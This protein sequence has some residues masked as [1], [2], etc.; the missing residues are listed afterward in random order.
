MREALGIRHQAA[1]GITPTNPAV[2]NVKIYVAQVPPSI[3][4]Q[5]VSHLQEEPLTGKGQRMGQLSGYEGGPNSHPVPQSFSDFLAALHV[6]PNYEN[7]G[8]AVS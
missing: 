8:L 2:I 6:N 7:P 1:C 3:L 4:C 5:P